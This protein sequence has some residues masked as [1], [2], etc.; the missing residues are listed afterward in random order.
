LSTESPVP[1]ERTTD[2]T[3]RVPWRMICGYFLAFLLLVL[4]VDWQDGAFQSEFGRN[5]DEGIHYVT[6]VLIRSFILNPSAWTHPMAFAQDFYAHYPKVGLGNWPPLFELLQA[7]WSLA[8]GFSRISILLEMAVMTAMLA[9]L[10]AYCFLRVAPRGWVYAGL[11][12]CLLILSPLTQ[13][14]SSMVMAE[15]P[16]A[17]LSLASILAWIRFE[18]S[19]RLRDAVM[20]G[21]LTSCAIL[22]KGNAWVIPPV[23]VLAIAWNGSWPLFK[24]RSFWIA[25][26]L[27]A[28]LCVP[29]TI[30]TMNI[31]TQGWNTRGLPSVAMLLSALPAHVRFVASILGIPILLLATLGAIA[32]IVVPKRRN[33]RQ[34]SFWSTML[35]YGVL[36][37]L[38]HTVVPTS[39]EP[40]K[41]YQ[42]APVV[43][44]FVAAA[45][46]YAC[47][48]LAIRITSR[49]LLECGLAAAALSLFLV[50]GFRWVEPF[51][52]DL[53]PIVSEL[54]KRPDTQGT[55]IL[56]AS[57][58]Y[59]QDLEAAFIAEWIS[60][61][62]P[63]GTFLVR[64]TKL[65]AR[66]DANE[67]QEIDLKSVA[68]SPASVRE[69]LTR[70][71]VS[72]VVTH[73]TIAPRTYA[74]HPIL[75]S[76]LEKSPEEWEK[77]DQRILQNNGRSH[78][79]A[80]YR[81]RKD[82][83]GVPVRFEIDLTQKI[84]Q[85]IEVGSPS[86]PNGQQ[87]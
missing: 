34:S 36:V 24:R 3:S 21:I 16:L 64:A 29:Y 14:Q 51:A 59:Y 6:G 8:F 80:L 86:Q 20:F 23:V 82:F 10:S 4:F 52:A 18:A 72:F 9:S 73:A 63:N 75:Q 61:A 38:F 40:R 47:E 81:S 31:V 30:L 79:V 69:I 37:I 41:V 45:L 77:L 7:L 1:P 58:A 11:A 35:I 26:A 48:V 39:F 44:L 49:W 78:E 2:D 65:L 43:C 83:R 66:A 19:G 71:P 84:K 60:Q 33:P 85:T 70:V 28:V 53:R 68:E 12:G 56:I 74:F 32:T 57:N 76:V 27:I 50:T 13:E 62:G 54:V 87:K 67:S 15:I 42:I 5:P 22:T 55:A 25:A 46:M 17:L